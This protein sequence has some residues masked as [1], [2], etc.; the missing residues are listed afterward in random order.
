MLTSKE[1]APVPSIRLQILGVDASCPSLDGPQF[2]GP[3]GEHRPQLWG[4]VDL[5]VRGV[6][7][8]NGFIDR[9]QGEYVTFCTRRQGQGLVYCLKSM[10]SEPYCRLFPYRRDFVLK[11]FCIVC[12]AAAH[13]LRAP[14]LRNGTTPRQSS[15]GTNM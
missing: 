10:G 9:L 4:V 7:V 6:V 14:A 8:V 11:Q 12:I 5:T 2:I 13:S 1:R 3:D 15:G